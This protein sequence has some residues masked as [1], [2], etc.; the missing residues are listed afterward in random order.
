MDKQTEVVKT[1]KSGKTK[2][3]KKQKQKMEVEL[4]LE[5]TKMDGMKC[6]MFRNNSYFGEKSNV[7]KSG[8]CKYYRRG[9][10]DKFEWCIVEMVLF[11]FKDSGLVSN[12]INR[13]KILL[14]EE[15]IF[16]DFGDLCKGVEMLIIKVMKFIQI[17]L[18]Y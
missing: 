6:G 14:M 4:G 7:L 8:I 16:V 11:G 9:I 2:T 17:K 12:L 13:L 1:N 5:S 15:M 18:D 10:W 3:N